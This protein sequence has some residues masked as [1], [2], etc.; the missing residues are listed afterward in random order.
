MRGEDLN[1]DPRL[2]HCADAARAEFGKTRFPEVLYV[3]I[4]N[5]VQRDQ[6]LGGIGLFRGDK[7]Q[8]LV[9]QR[10]DRFLCRG[11]TGDNGRRG[12]PGTNTKCSRAS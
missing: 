9:S 3:L 5:R 1:I 7:W 11:S 10:D 8:I 12:Q 2:I 6:F 4:V